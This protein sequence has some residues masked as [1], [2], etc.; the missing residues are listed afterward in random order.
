MPSLALCYGDVIQLH[1]DQGGGFLQAEGFCD[2]QAFASGSSAAALEDFHASLFQIVPMLQYASRR[3]LQELS[4]E[5][6]LRGPSG[7]GVG[8]ARGSALRK[9]RRPAE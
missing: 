6:A 7:G 3:E 9:L 2:T 1:A 4:A 8:G 5:A